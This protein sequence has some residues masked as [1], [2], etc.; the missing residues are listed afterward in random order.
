M[1]DR[2]ELDFPFD[3]PTEFLSLESDARLEANPRTIRDG[4]LEE[5]G[6]FLQAARRE[7][8]EQDVEYVL[9]PTDGALDDFLIRYLASR[10]AVSRSR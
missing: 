6:K 8:R 4:Y 9:T 10:R 3:D 5:F 7:L 2:D 1:L